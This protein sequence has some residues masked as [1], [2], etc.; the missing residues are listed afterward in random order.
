MCFLENCV[1]RIRYCEVPNLITR[2]SSLSRFPEMFQTVKNISLSMRTDAFVLIS[3][4][5]TWF[6]Q[7]SQQSKRCIPDDDVFMPCPSH[8]GR[9]Y[10]VGL[11]SHRRRE[12]GAADSRGRITSWH[13]VPFH[14]LIEPRMY[15]LLQ[16]STP[17]SATMRSSGVRKRNKTQ[18]GDCRQALR[19]VLSIIFHLWKSTPMFSFATQIQ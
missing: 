1:C 5:S 7:I 17:S 15:T 6:A 11:G 13:T 12:G 4:H 9:A 2:D 3:L 16:Q 8:T 19:I 10:S 18:V 14:P